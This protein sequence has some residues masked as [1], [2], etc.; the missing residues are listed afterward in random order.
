VS[1]LKRHF[2]KNALGLSLCLYAS[3]LVCAPSVQ[4]ESDFQ[5]YDTPRFTLHI[6]SYT[7][8]EAVIIP[9][10]EKLANISLNTLNDTF[11]ELS[12]IFKLQPSRKVILKFLT[13]SEFSKQTGAPS[14]TNAMYYRGEISIPMS[15]SN[16]SELKDLNRAI[17]HEYVHAFIAEITNHRCP[18]WLDEGIAQLIEGRPNPVLGPALRKWIKTN[19]SIPL[20]WLQN[21]FTLL[22]DNV[23]PTAYAQSLFVT[24]TLVN[25]HGFSALRDYLLALRDGQ[26]SRKAFRTAFNTDQVVFEKDLSQQI[27]RWADSK[28][29]NP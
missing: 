22:D 13:P 27:R 24:R 21:G 8:K 14:W 11:D 9:D 5:V 19:N 17:R 6:G 25:R 2:T 7:E 1:N 3:L 29:V 15:K 28:Q 23:V 16:L 20:D 4:A 26:D 12:R 18:A 10:N